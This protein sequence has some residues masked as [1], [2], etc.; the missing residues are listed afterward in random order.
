MRNYTQ[1]TKEQRYQISALLKTEQSQTQIAKV[2]GVNKS[3]ISRE[4]KRNKGRKGYR[5][6]QADAKALARKDKSKVH[7]NQEQWEQVDQ[8]LRLDWSPE[9][10][11]DQLLILH[12]RTISHEWIYQY[13]L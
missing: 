8:W 11:H 13:V 6:K 2:I 4:L 9:Q 10:I 7:I 5:P 12:E 3:T 1:L